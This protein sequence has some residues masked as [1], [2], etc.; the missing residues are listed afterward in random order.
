MVYAFCNLSTFASSDVTSGLQRVSLSGT[1]R[2][3][4]S[5]E[6]TRNTKEIKGHYTHFLA[7]LQENMLDLQKDGILD[8][9]VIKSQIIMLDRKLK[10]PISDCRS[11]QEIF[12]ILQSPE[13]SSFLDYELVKVFVDYG[14]NKL[15]GDFVNYKKKL[16]KFLEKRIIERSSGGEKLFAVV[17]DESIT[18]NI[19]DL[20]QLENRVNYFGE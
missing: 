9:S 12:E 5:C 11:L 13:H 6:L 16:Q 17:I 19:T 20:I 1:N 10:T 14:N 18:N 2:H 8:V 15:K 4:E 7:E 3:F